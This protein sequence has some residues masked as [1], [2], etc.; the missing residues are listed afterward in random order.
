[1]SDHR[2]W[3]D[4]WCPYCGAAA[5]ARCQE[6]WYSRKRPSLA[7]RLHVAR[8]WRE[9][10]C[11]TC[12]ACPG[13][14]CHTPSGRE[15]SRPHSARLRP[16]RRELV[17]HQT[18]WEELERRGATFAVIPFSGRAGQ[19]G[20]IGAITLNRLEGD[21]FVDVERWTGR[22][23]LTL[24]LEGPVWDRYAWFAGQPW[25]RGT[26]AWTVT[27]RS[28]LIIGRRGDTGFEEVFA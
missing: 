10:P 28:I 21:E 25:I 15:A 2:A 3:L 22:D 14:P 12:K 13:D 17:G 23:E 24:A 11:P 5:G 7:R 20:R 6:R 19:G 18:V 4:Q 1:M 8:G 26:V 27:D 9:R 16:G